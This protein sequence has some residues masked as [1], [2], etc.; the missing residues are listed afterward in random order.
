MDM[1]IEKEIFETQTSSLEIEKKSL[2]KL[3]EDKQMVQRSLDKIREAEE[4]IDRLEKY[5][6]KLDIYLEFEKALALNNLSF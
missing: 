5:I 6:P 2:A 4:E 1:E 3:E